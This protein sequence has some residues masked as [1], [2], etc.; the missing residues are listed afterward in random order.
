VTTT[1]DLGAA[2]QRVADLIATIRDEQL[3]APTPCPHYSVGDLIDHFEG[4]TMAFRDAATKQFPESGPRAALGSASNLPSDWRTQ[5]PDD[6]SELAAAWRDPEAWTGMT[7]AGPVNL[8]GEIAGLVV[9]NELVVHGWDLARATGQP[10]D[11]DAATLTTCYELASQFADP[12]GPVGP[13]VPFGRPLDV[14]DD[15]P[16]L[17]RLIA[18]TGREPGWTAG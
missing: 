4:I 2:A 14:G 9:L 13:D 11:C 12:Q 1:I 5:V 3:T 16:V 10:F 6:L 18:I 15:A 17:D 8:P 7:K